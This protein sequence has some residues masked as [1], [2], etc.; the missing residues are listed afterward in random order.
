MGCFPVA[1]DN[2]GRVGNQT[3][4]LSENTA[5]RNCNTPRSGSFCPNCGQRHIDLERPMT[6]LI[7]EVLNE[8]LDI[9]GRAFRT[10]RILLL[11]PG[12]LTREFLAGRRRTFTSPLRLYLVISAAFFVL[13]AWLAARGVLLD[14][15]QTIN[16]DAARQSQ[17]FS[18]EFPRLIFM[19]LPGYALLL[20][21]AFWRRLYFDHLIYS[22]H[23]HSAAFVMLAISIPMEKAASEHW[24]PM[25]AQTLL[26]VYFLA[27][28]AISMR[29][30]YQTSWP[31]ASFKSI[32]ILI[33]H[34]LI[35][36]YAATVS[37][38]IDPTP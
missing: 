31:V 25:L 13:L 4:V 22:V 7:G 38:T 12:V 24:L 9:D 20:K 17:I 19:L 33:A 29:R 36:G 26:L 8:S 18:N 27:Y 16:E 37:G 6:Q 10:L 23:L 35:I 21:L 15:G 5:C 32:V 3:T 1:G 14:P 2:T 11:Q 30:V 28:C 34:L